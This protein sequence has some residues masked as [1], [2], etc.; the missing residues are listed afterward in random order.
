MGLLG[1]LTGLVSGLLGAVVGLVS[2]VL[3]GVLALVLAVLA[4]VLLVVAAL[5][6]ATILLLPLGIPLGAM[7][8]D[9]YGQA[10]KILTGNTGPERT[11]RRAGDALRARRRRSP[12]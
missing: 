9:L 8:L 6:C 11:L 4:T 12:I 7:A 2:A 10:A 5:L 1:G 3:R